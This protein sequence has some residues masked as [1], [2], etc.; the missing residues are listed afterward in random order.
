[1]DVPTI[2]EFVKTIEARVAKVALSPTPDTETLLRLSIQV[3]VAE[4]KI[5]EKLEKAVG[6]ERKKLEEIMSRTRKIRDRIIRMYIALMLRGESK[7]PPT[8]MEV[9]P[10]P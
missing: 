9:K 7:H 4:K 6:V 5:E 3:L 8:I 2:E 1:M 10:W